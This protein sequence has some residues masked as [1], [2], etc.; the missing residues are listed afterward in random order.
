MYLSD[1]LQLCLSP[2]ES[3][4][5]QC[6]GAEVPGVGKDIGVLWGASPRGR[7][8]PEQ[9][10]MAISEPSRSCACATAHQEAVLW[11]DHH[12]N[13]FIAHFEWLMDK[14]LGY[15]LCFNDGRMSIVFPSAET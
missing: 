1:I 15:V 9:G 6:S 7:T 3:K 14:V 12:P 4:A 11:W 13:P 8:W 10:Q 5:Q 2:E